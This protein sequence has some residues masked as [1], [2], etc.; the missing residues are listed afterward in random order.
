MN[1]GCCI[2]E[3]TSQRVLLLDR[4]E[5]IATVNLNLLKV[6]ENIH[7]LAVEEENIIFSLFICNFSVVTFIAILL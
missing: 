5:T 1:I 4:G 7:A 2:L 6:S 3:G